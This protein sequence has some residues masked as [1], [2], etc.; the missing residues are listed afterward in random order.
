MDETLRT[1]L[2][3]LGASLLLLSPPAHA[4]DGVIEI[5]QAA[6]LV[7][8]VTTSDEP[9]F[10][11]TLDSPGSYRLTGNLTLPNQNTDAIVVDADNVTIDLG[12]FSIIGT[13]NC[14][15]TTGSIECSNS[16]SGRGIYATTSGIPVPGQADG[17]VIKNGTISGTGS[18]AIEVRKSAWIDGVL[19]THCASTAIRAEDDSLV[20]DSRVRLVGGVGLFAVSGVVS[21]RGS[22]FALVGGATH[23]G[24][25]EIGGNTCDDA[26]CSA[27]PQRHYYLTQATSLGGGVLTACDEGFH[28]AT[29]HEISAPG[30]LTYDWVRG[31][32]HLDSGKGPPANYFGWVRSGRDIGLPIGSGGSA[33][34][35]VWASS[36]ITEFGSV[37]ALAFGWTDSG[38]KMSPWDSGSSTCSDSLPVWCIED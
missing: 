6:A 2:I 12:G 24:A 4:V 27:V 19:V 22:R 14:S 9:G 37:A 13:A 34:C 20:T 33:N 25:T 35:R 11:V 16:G 32:N 23:I 10:P 29:L 8:G 18:Y 28:T 36:S 31:E 1:S 17:T 26:R 3:G 30:A 5:N 7:G 38:E 15:G 21:F